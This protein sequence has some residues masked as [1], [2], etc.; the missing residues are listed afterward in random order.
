[1]EHQV[2]FKEAYSSSLELVALLKSRDLAILDNAK[3]AHGFTRIVY[4]WLPA[5]IRPA[6]QHS[7][8]KSLTLNLQ[9]FGISLGYQ[10]HCAIQGLL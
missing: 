4:Y 8:G 3:V 5:N 2:I 7:E 10:L 1:M 9:P 6:S